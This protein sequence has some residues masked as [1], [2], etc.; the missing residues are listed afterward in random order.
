MVILLHYTFQQ[1]I[2][3]DQWNFQHPGITRKNAYKQTGMR[4]V[5]IGILAEVFSILRCS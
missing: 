3:L 2:I 1:K 4:V 5:D